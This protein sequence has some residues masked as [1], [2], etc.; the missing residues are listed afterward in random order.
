MTIIEE[1][2]KVF[3]EAVAGDGISLNYG[4]LD[5]EDRADLIGGMRA[6]VRVLASAAK[7]DDIRDWLLAIAEEGETP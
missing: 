2:T 1:M 3:Y 4:F 5:Q 7:K 6:A